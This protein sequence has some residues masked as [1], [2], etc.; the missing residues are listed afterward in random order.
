MGW[1]PKGFDLQ[2]CLMAFLLLWLTANLVT[3]LYSFAAALLTAGKQ[4]LSPSHECNREKGIGGGAEAGAGPRR[5]S[6]GR[7]HIFACREGTGQILAL[8]GAL[9]VS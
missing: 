8:Q 7:S 4:K 2:G 9:A 5:R 6:K 3:A 1:P